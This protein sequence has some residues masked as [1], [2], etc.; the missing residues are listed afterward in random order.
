MGFIKTRTAYLN[1]EQK[2]Y[3]HMQRRIFTKGI[4][5]TKVEQKCKITSRKIERNWRFK[6]FISLMEMV[7]IFFSCMFE[8]YF[9]IGLL[10]DY[11]FMSQNV[12]YCCCDSFCNLGFIFLLSCYKPVLWVFSP[13]F[14]FCWKC[15]WVG[16]AVFFYY[17]TLLKII[18]KLGGFYRSLVY[19]SKASI[20][21]NERTN[22]RKTEKTEKKRER[23]CKFKL[24][25]ATTE[26]RKIANKFNFPHYFFP[27]FN[28]PFIYFGLALVFIF[29]SS[30]SS[31]Q[32]LFGWLCVERTL[33]THT[34]MS[35]WNSSSHLC[36]TM[37][38]THIEATQSIYTSKWNTFADVKRNLFH[39]MVRLFALFYIHM[40]NYAYLCVYVC[41][42]LFRSVFLYVHVY[43]FALPTWHQE[44][45]RK[46]RVVLGIGD[47]ARKWFAHHIHYLSN[48]IT[49]HQIF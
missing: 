26:Y 32:L 42:M 3:T 47:K 31:Q 19:Y 48:V 27:H 5:K 44:R 11:L 12:C 24:C 28:V 41:K 7:M 8:G 1:G 43:V 36:V 23:T 22:E 37:H 9:C 14:L 21:A 45:E 49:I 25:Y 39:H 33:Y 4:I 16:E 34:I 13:A 20:R 15:S 2:T 40:R 6:I 30:S 18:S 46:H 17:C 29:T 35:F 10:Y 38:S